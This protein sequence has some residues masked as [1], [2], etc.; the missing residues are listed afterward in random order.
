MTIQDTIQNQFMWTK[1][2]E[3]EK[4]EPGRLYPK[5]KAAL[6]ALR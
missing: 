1:F 6:D 2:I 5:A 3:P 4:T